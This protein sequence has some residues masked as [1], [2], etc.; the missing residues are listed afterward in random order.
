MTDPITITLLG[1][2]LSPFVSK[3]TDNFLNRQRNSVAVTELQ[4]QVARLLD[5]RDDLEIES[6][7]TRMAVLAFARNLAF[8]QHD[9]FVLKG[10]R[11]EVLGR[12][13]SGREELIERAIDDFSLSLEAR[14][15]RIEARR[16]REA[17]PYPR[18]TFT[19]GPPSNVGVAT[20]EALAKF[21]DGFE[22]EVMRARMGRDE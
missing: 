3:L 7:Q 14:L 18:P 9:I 17:E 19:P 22:E 13:S 2:V 12:P 8:T 10:D 15:K 4:D 6:I 21:F 5:S 11:L 20:P 16:A 1:A